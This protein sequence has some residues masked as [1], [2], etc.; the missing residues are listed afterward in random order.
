MNEDEWRMNEG[1]MRVE[2]KFFRPIQTWKSI[3]IEDRK[4]IKKLIK[5]CF[6]KKNVSNEI[7]LN[8]TMNEG[9]MNNEWWRLKSIL[10]E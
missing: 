9:W 5:T 1:W 3:K 2:W 7:T 10:N 8:R 4:T 6:G